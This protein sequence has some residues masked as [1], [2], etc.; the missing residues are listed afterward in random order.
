[1]EQSRRRARFA[2]A[3]VVISVLLA[4]AATGLVPGTG[5]VAQPVEPVPVGAA[6]GVAGPDGHAPADD[7]CVA[8]LTVTTEVNGP[9][10]VGRCAPPRRYRLV[11][12]AV[13]IFTLGCL[14]A[15][16]A[17]LAVSAW[18]SQ[19]HAA[20]ADAADAAATATTESPTTAATTDRAERVQT[21]EQDSTSGTQPGVSAS[22]RTEA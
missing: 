15:V 2:S 19:R 20:A 7:P 10:P 16:L 4:A 1:M 17:A 12:S 5:A 14:A 22:P 21:R 8:G 9:A 3:I 6:D 18:R 13:W 11:D